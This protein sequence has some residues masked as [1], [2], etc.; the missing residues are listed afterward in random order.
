MDISNGKI[1]DIKLNINLID[2][3]IE[4]ILILD[5]D[6]KILFGNKSAVE[7][8][9]YTYEELIN[10]N[11]I[12]IIDKNTEVND[13][14]VHE[15]S[16]SATHYKKDGTK[17]YA[18]IKPFYSDKKSDIIIVNISRGAYCLFELLKENSIIS[19]A[20]EVFEDAF[21]VLTKD[22]NVY[23]WS[24]SAEKK[25]GY[26][27]NEIFG[28]NI[29]E[30]IPKNRIN[31]FESKVEKI[32]QNKTIEG[33]ETKRKGK[34]GNLI[35]VSITMAPLY[36]CSGRF[37]GVLGI[38]K[39]ITEKIKLEE[40][41]KESEER[42]RLALEGG[43]FGIWDWNVVSNEL[44]C[45]FLFT[46]LFGHL[47]NEIVK[48]QEEFLGKIHMDDKPY[49]MDSINRHF[50]GEEFDIE[51]RMKIKDNNYKWIRSKGKVIEWTD[52]SKPLRMV[53]I[54]EDITD[55]KSI[56]VEF[57]EKCKQLEILKE[58]AESAS[59]AK[60]QFLANMSHEIRT[61]MNGIFG[62][63]QLIKSTDLSKEQIKYVNLINESLNN[64]KEIIDDILDISKIE[65]GKITINEESFDLRKTVNSIYSNLLVTGNS[66]DLEI[67]YYLDPNINF[68]IISD[69][70]KI[71]QILNNL[72]SNAVKFTSRGYISFR[73]K[74]IEN[75]QDTVKIEFRIKDTGIGI[76]D[77]IKDKLFQEFTQGDISTNKKFNG[78][79]LGLAIS[80]QL[81]NILKGNICFESKLNGGSIFVFTCE[82]KKDISNTENQQKD[83]SDKRVCE[84]AKQN[85]EFTIL[86]VEDNIINQEVIESLITRKGY[87]LIAAYNGREAL[88]VLKE[89]KVDL[90][91]M[92]IQMPELNGFQTTELIRKEIDI[93][94]NIPIIAITA[95]AMREDREKCIDAGM[96]DYISK[97]FNI[98]E[99][100]EVIETYLR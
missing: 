29:R 60:S 91:L 88:N 71:K 33:F 94:C 32:K 28:K 95:Y 22:L 51:F 5:N 47:E 17:F 48:Y 93:E 41:L 16:V 92:D 36:D 38:Y 74:I 8:Y 54:Q 58:K 31:E 69:E 34:N 43:R 83:I 2:S 3:L 63:V 87:K 82:F 97:P 20:L 86:S 27:K 50:H 30:L 62:M 99:F 66:R 45:S 80:K 24:K 59:K 81:A 39:D 25:F 44:F 4:N 49:V 52:D 56:E 68:Q 23:L 13:L 19:K 67:S 9:G 57:N 100:Y 12:N 98:D 89:N 6:G 64:L 42:L 77:E 79:G 21:V 40:Q 10:L 15:K 11:I 53:G 35:D 18:E 78:T 55:K 46:D 14:L 96:T 26:L 75:Y 76:K 37:N 90:I 72:V 61:P 84:F 1:K 65:S 85:Q 70:L 73:T 7:M